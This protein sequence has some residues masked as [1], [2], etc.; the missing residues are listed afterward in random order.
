MF[1]NGSILGNGSTPCSPLTHFIAYA[2]DHT[3]LPEVVGFHRPFSPRKIKG[4]ISHRS[5]IQRPPPLHF[6]VHDRVEGA[7]RQHVFQQVVVYRRAESLHHKGGKPDGAGDVLVCGMAA[8]RRGPEARA[9][10]LRRLRFQLLLDSCAC[11][12][13]VESVTPVLV[14]PRRTSLHWLPNCHG[15]LRWIWHYLSPSCCCQSGYS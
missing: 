7:L 9:D 2:I 3:R 1:L 15:F 6:D 11:G 8:L 10:S 12:L 14:T 5:R 13:H 4:A